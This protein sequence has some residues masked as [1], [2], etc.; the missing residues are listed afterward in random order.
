M[1]VPV[2]I[3]MAGGNHWIIPKI[4]V[5]M[6]CNTSEYSYSLPLLYLIVC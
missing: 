5:Y 3:E 2:L 6:C 4:L 1:I